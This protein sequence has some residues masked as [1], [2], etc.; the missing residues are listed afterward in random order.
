[1]ETTGRALPVQ[2]LSQYAWKLADGL[3]LY[4]WYISVKGLG[5]DCCEISLRAMQSLCRVSLKWQWVSSFYHLCAGISDTMGGRVYVLPWLWED[6]LFKNILE[7]TLKIFSWNAKDTES[8]LSRIEHQTPVFKISSIHASVGMWIEAQWLRDPGNRRYELQGNPGSHIFT[9]GSSF[10]VRGVGKPVWSYFYFLLGSYRF[11]NMRAGSS[12][13]AASVS[14]L[15]VSQTQS[16]HPLW[17]I[18]GS[19]LSW[20]L[21]RLIYLNLFSIYYCRAELLSSFSL[22][23]A[24]IR[25]ALPLH[26]PASLDLLFLWTFKISSPY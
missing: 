25:N 1:M 19:D 9:M 7:K 22:L 20:N 8:R 14:N 16:L 5:H 12:H 26:C 6:V 18:T 15:L 13:W 24:S 23:I 10:S 4:S 2:L 11:L 21:K 3:L 17:L